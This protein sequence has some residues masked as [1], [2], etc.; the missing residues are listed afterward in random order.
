MATT[1]NEPLNGDWQAI[2]VGGEVLLSLPHQH[3]GSR[4]IY[5]FTDNDQPPVNL[6][7]AHPL[8]DAL[9]KSMR[10]ASGETLWVKGRDDILVVTAENPVT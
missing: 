2:A 7:Y 10:L 4:A 1:T 8:T 5:A 3:D 9:D 6:T